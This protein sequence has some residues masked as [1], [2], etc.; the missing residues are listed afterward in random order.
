[1]TYWYVFTAITGRERSVANR[2]NQRFRNDEITAFTPERTVLFRRSGKVQKELQIMFPGYV[3]VESR[4]RDDEFL[5][6][7]SQIVRSSMHIRKLLKYSDSGEIAVR[8]DERTSLMLLMNDKHHLE[9]STCFIEGDRICITEGPLL[10]RECIIHKI[11]SHKMEAIIV[12]EILGDKR[13]VTIGLEV[14]QR[15]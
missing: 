8:E 7:S 5:Y 13:L 3:F 9:P 12:L 15:V 14:I 6:Q 1:M 11:N 2:V 4:L 10:G